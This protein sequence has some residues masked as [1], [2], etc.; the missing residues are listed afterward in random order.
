MSR[1]DQS[2]SLSI[3]LVAHSFR[4]TDGLHA[5]PSGKSYGNEG[6]QGGRLRWSLE[7]SL[8]ATVPKVQLLLLIERSE[9]MG[10]P[11]AKPKAKPKAKHY[12]NRR[13][14]CPRFCGQQTLDAAEC[15]DYFL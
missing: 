5:K 15:I 11:R 13:R 1:T 3:F 14:S 8:G 7:V 2:L 10:K 6:L 9:R 4:V 12:P